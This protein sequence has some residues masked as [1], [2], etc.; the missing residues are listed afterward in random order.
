M[1]NL[2]DYEAKLSEYVGGH[3]PLVDSV[4]EDQGKLGGRDYFLLPDPLHYNQTSSFR[5]RCP[6]Q[7][8]SIMQD[9]PAHVSMNIAN[10][11]NWDQEEEPEDEDTTDYSFQGISLPDF[12]GST[13]KTKTP[14]PSQGISHHAPIV[15]DRNMIAHKHKSKFVRTTDVSDEMRLDV[16]VMLHK[17]DY[18]EPGSTE[19]RKNWQMATYALDQKPKIWHG[20]RHRHKIVSDAEEGDA[21]KHMHI[22]QVIVCTLQCVKEGEHCARSMGGGSTTLA[23]LGQQE[24]CK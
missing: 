13:R 21:S 3:R 10:Q 20:T 17:E 15:P 14:G 5:N 9:C 24:I 7:G 22:Q 11:G 19:Y 4:E 1:T 23:A 18:G 6:N 8:T 12:E 2:D 16:N